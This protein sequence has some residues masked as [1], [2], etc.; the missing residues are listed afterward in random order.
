VA[1]RGGSSN[2]RALRPSAL[3]APRDRKLEVGL[4]Y[5]Q[6]VVISTS[7]TDSPLE[8]NTLLLRPM[9][10]DRQAGYIVERSNAVYIAASK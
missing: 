5:V 2:P 9:T 1:L 3:G 8:N 6:K 10:F 7:E 4:G